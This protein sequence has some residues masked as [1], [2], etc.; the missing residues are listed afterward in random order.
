[1]GV[2]CAKPATHIVETDE[3][4]KARKSEYR[5]NILTNIQ[6]KEKVFKGDT[7]LKGRF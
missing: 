6:E 7:L 4:G 5:K 2:Q 1:M 3:I